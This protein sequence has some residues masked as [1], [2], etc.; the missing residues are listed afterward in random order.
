M[1]FGQISYIATNPRIVFHA[2]WQLSNKW[3]GKWNILRESWVYDEFWSD[4]PY[5]N[6]PQNSV[7]CQLTA[8]QQVM[9]KVKYFTRELSVWWVLDRYPILQQTPEKCLRIFNAEELISHHLKS[10]HPLHLMLH[11]RFPTK[12]NLSPETLF[13]VILIW[14]H[15]AFLEPCNHHWVWLPLV[16]QWWFVPLNII[17]WQQ[18]QHNKIVWLC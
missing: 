14:N 10:C 9:G 11:G 13:C 1:S 5:C 15:V 17:C 7:S 12:T 6:K 8:K 18:K 2:I 4:I 3:W 16:N